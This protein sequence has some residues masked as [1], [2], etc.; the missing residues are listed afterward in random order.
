MTDELPGIP[1]A[2]P[3]S[4]SPL[5]AR[6]LALFPDTTQIAIRK[7]DELLSIA[8]CYLDEL[9][10]FYGTPL[11][12]YDQATLD[13]AVLSYRQALATYPALTGITYAGKAYLCKAVAQWAQQKGLK[14]DCTGGGELAIA[15]AAR[16]SKEH[17]LV[18]GV[19][20][21]QADLDAALAHAGIIVVDH[22]SELKRLIEMAS[23]S[24][25]PI[26]EIW[27]RFQP[28][29]AVETHNFLQTGQAE[30]KF[31]MKREEVLE[32][33]RICQEQHLPL[34]GLHFHLGSNFR[35]ATSIRFALSQSLDLIEAIDRKGEWTLCPGGGLAV[36][37]HED[38]LPQPSITSFIE[39]IVEALINGCRRRRLPLPRLQI[40]PGRS[41]I[42]RAG[43]A[44]YRLGAIKRSEQRTW[45]LLDGGLADNPR[46]ALYG[47][48]YSA[49]PV[50]LP[51][52]LP[53]SQV[54][55]AGPYCESGD[56]L[57]EALPFA[58]VQEGELIAI[59]VSGAYHLS[60]ASNYNGACRPAVLWLKDSKAQLIQRRETPEDLLR[61][62]IGLT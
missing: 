61:R 36:A 39:S 3:Q 53:T 51:N 56:I 55:M 57:I 33:A 60:M 10:D 22:L 62:D 19:N 9:A 37:Y 1:E 29:V 32:A 13:S 49:L 41:L 7:S 8:G 21:T 42:A 38:D 50:W 20:K 26:P 24:T 18:H 12:L 15:I 5:T 4:I 2:R 54:W 34:K 45:L 44:L 48:R 14:V 6:R 31:G 11:Y 17:I 25:E 52:R 35:E 27:L 59:P 40:E 43:V 46:H 28:G 47:A 16:V 58:E 30:S 23:Q